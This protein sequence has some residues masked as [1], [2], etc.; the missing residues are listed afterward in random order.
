M[1]I[2]SCRGAISPANARD[3]PVNERGQRSCDRSLCK[4]RVM[5]RS[6]S[7]ILGAV[8]SIGA[9]EADAA[10]RTSIARCHRC[11][12]PGAR[13]L[14]AA[15]RVGRARAT[16]HDRFVQVTEGV[17]A[18]ERAGLPRARGRA[19]TIARAR[20]ARRDDRRSRSTAGAARELR[21]ELAGAEH[22]V[23]ELRGRRRAAAP[24]ARVGRARR[25]SASPGSARATRCA[26][27][28]PGARSSSAPTAPTPAPTAR[29][30]CASS[31]ASR[32]ATTRP[33]RS[34]SPAAATRCGARPTPTARASSS[35]SRRAVVDARRAPARCACTSSPTRRPSPACAATCA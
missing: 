17:I 12:A 24:R 35:T 23:L 18:D 9:I 29:P 8:S 14:R 26:S 27:T 22:L 13:L 4:R 2:D 5:R 6:V 19:P 7:A 30:T 11:A 31:A 20:R 28:T 16:V 33:R 25:R 21:V 34:C 32:R 1:S 3:R 15:D 10:R